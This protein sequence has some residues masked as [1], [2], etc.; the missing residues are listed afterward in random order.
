VNVGN[1]IPDQE[2]DL[3]NALGLVSCVA[4]ARSWDALEPLFH[5]DHD[6]QT[7]WRLFEPLDGWWGNGR[8]EDNFSDVSIDELDCAE[9]IVFDAPIDDELFVDEGELETFNYKWTITLEFAFGF[10]KDPTSWVLVLPGAKELQIDFL[11]RRDE[12]LLEKLAQ[13]ELLGTISAAGLRDMLIAFLDL[14]ATAFGRI[15]HRIENHESTRQ[16]FTIARAMLRDL[17]ELASVT[18]ERSTEA[19][20]SLLVAAGMLGRGLVEQVV[21]T[22][23][24]GDDGQENSPA[25]RAR[26]AELLADI[27]DY[28]NSV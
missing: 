6:R 21:D 20:R 26:S 17:V 16:E 22:W 28:G 19:Q 24:V 25:C 9:R 12:L 2:R 15:A 8:D 23:S 13:Q 1:S 10:V 7:G 27:E 11:R 5:G 3:H 18:E 14:M 4:L